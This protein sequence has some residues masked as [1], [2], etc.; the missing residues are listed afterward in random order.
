MKTRYLYEAIDTL[1]GCVAQLLRQT[2]FFKE[3]Y[4]FFKIFISIN[5]PPSSPKLA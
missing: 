4:E 1:L 3:K 5:Q 2:E